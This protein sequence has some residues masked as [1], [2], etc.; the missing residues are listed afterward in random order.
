MSIW[1]NIYDIYIYYMTIYVWTNQDHHK[2]SLSY[3][4][5]EPF[6]VIPLDADNL[7]NS[8]KCQL[9]KLTRDPQ[10][11]SVIFLMFTGSLVVSSRDSVLEILSQDFF[12]SAGSRSPLWLVWD[13]KCYSATSTLVT[14]GMTNITYQKRVIHT[15]DGG[16]NHPAFSSF[17]GPWMSRWKLVDTRLGSVG[18]GPQG[19]PHL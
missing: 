18:Y 9:T 4:A 8:E 17:P 12:S 15:V 19:I 6:G 10:Y 11:G 1:F 13:R 7:T 16:E 3:I 14:V 2:T 5:T